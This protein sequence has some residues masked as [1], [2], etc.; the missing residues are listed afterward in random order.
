[1]QI[2]FKV[3]GLVIA[4]VL[5]ATVILA[6]L[7]Y[8]AARRQY[9]AGIDRQ[10]ISLA[11][12]LPGVLGADYLEQAAGGSVAGNAYERMVGTLS[13]LA[14]RSGVYYLYVFAL[15][16]GSVVHL[17]TSA[18]PAEREAGDWAV[19]RQ[20]YEEPPAALLRTFA[21]GRTR[22]AE[23]TDEFGSFRS[24]LVRHE[25]GEGRA[26]VM[27]VDV[28]LSRVHAEQLSIVLHAAIAGLAVAGL[29]GAAGV[30]VARRMTRPIE[31]LSRE[32]H[33]WADRG[34]AG[35]PEIRAHLGELAR[36]HR[37]EAGDLAAKFVEVQ[38]RLETYLRELTET[39]AAKERIEQQMEIAKGIQE[40]LLPGEM[41]RIPNFEVVG[42][43]KPADE[44]GGDYFDWVTLADGRL[45]ITIGDVTGH[46][47]GPALLAAAS[48][49]YARATLNAGDELDA[50]IARLNVQ[51][52][53]DMGGSRFVTLVACLLDPAARRATLVAA[54]HGPIM[55]YSRARDEITASMDTQGLPLGVTDT[56]DYDRPVELCFEPGDTLVLVSDGFF[57]WGN[58]KGQSFGIARL[59]RSVVSACR[60]CPDRIIERLRSDLEEFSDGTA[61]QDDTTA[62]VVRCVG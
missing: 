54:G 59:S 62:L 23:Y 38:D 61:Q 45:L 56:L 4:S 41:P 26:C 50:M 51:L 25:T 52:L 49:A 30:V 6:W 9:I 2:R 29:T 48:R 3:C 7:G 11:A 46:G 44:T 14:D 35:D 10:L 53:R 21:D 43:N 36:R 34:F 42:W 5:L 58:G 20:P 12:A 33:T 39:T 22:F 8:D 40:S 55:F 37:D 17:A 31:A 18:S 27:G 32:V 60:E 28:T 24:V 57:E 15:D 16:E 47:I 19:F 13:D 1:M